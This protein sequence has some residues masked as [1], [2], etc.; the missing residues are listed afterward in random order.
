[1][2]P[3][4]RKASLIVGTLALM[5][6]GAQTQE[7]TA[8]GL[9]AGMERADMTYRELME[10]MG[11]ASGMMHEG[12]LRQNPQMVKS[13]THIILTHPAPSHDPW[14]IMAEEDQTGFKSS[15]VAFDKLLDQSAQATT[16]AAL[17][18]DWAAASRAL[19]EL[20]NSCVGCH[21]MWKD[22]VK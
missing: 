8:E 13:G 2:T 3:L 7:G 11:R 16:D 15:L 21:A 17:Q 9:V 14:T 10:I 19:Q 18:R 6:G 4:V 12:I 20:N 5:V 22:K 1:M